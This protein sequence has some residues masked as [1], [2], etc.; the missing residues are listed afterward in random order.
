MRKISIVVGVAALLTL[1][2]QALLA[3]SL[4]IETLHPHRKPVTPEKRVQTE[5]RVRDVHATMKDVQIS[6]FDGANLRA[7]FFRP[8]EENGA[9]VIVL[10][11]HGDN[12][13]GSS[14]FAPMLLLHH[15]AVLAPDSRAHGDS[16]GEIATF[17]YDEARDL[18]GWVSWLAGENYQGCIYALGESMGAAIVLQALPTEP[19]ICA[20]VAES[21]YASFREIGYE[22]L[23]QRFGDGSFARRLLVVPLVG[24][25][26]VYARLRYGVDLD[27]VSPATRVARTTT[28]VLLIHGMSDFNIPVRHCREILQHHSGPMELWEVPGAGHTQAY[29]TEPEEFERRVTDWFDSH[30]TR[31]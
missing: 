5:E 10:H 2:L 26:F 29:R 9:A 6:S 17:G 31:N 20:A 7:W 12:R 8:Q 23:T 22:R 30:K 18:S 19:R 4:C 16:G 3:V 21:P 15:Y 28:P 14:G 24:E 27:Q 13:G 25:G 11:G 1:S